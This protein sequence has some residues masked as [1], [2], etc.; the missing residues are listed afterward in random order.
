MDKNRSIILD[1]LED[2][3]QGLFRIRSVLQH[4]MTVDDIETLL[5]ER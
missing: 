4:A 1:E 3:R 5:L 2:M